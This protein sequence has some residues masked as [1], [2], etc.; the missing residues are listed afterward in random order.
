MPKQNIAQYFLGTEAELQHNNVT[1][2]RIREL[3]ANILYLETVIKSQ[4]GLI[5]ELECRVD[6]YSQDGEPLC[7][8]F[9]QKGLD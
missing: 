7:D 3:E 6:P 2:R 5:A 8:S 1:Y 4:A 9:W